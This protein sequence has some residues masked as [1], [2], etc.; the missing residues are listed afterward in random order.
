M[1]AQNFNSEN[2]KAHYD[3]TKEQAIAYLFTTGAKALVVTGQKACQ[4][5]ASIGANEEAE[6]RKEIINEERVKLI[7][8]KLSE[9]N[10]IVVYKAS[11]NEHL[12]TINLKIKRDAHGQT[13]F[14]WKCRNNI[15][16]HFFFNKNTTV[17]PVITA[18]SVSL[19]AY[20]ANPKS[21]TQYNFQS[22]STEPMQLPYLHF[23]NNDRVLDIRFQTVYEMEAC[24][25][26]LGLSPSSV[27]LTAGPSI[28]QTHRST[29]PLR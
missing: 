7:K 8:R 17:E 26:L 25:E 28:S 20:Y 2:V 11:K 19:A 6:L 18:Q 3:N 16:K 10:P 1:I 23:K 27:W 29:S 12:R 24:L 4:S 15:K 22:T 5:D 14:S 9:N 13:F 21:T